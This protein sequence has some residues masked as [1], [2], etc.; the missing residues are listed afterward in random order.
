MGLYNP[1]RPPQQQAW[2]TPTLSPGWSN[3]GGIYS[4][5]AY[6]KDSLGVVHLK[7]ILICSEEDNVQIFVLPMGYRP[8]AVESFNSQYVDDLGV[9][10]LDRIEVSPD[11]QVYS[12]ADQTGQQFSLCGITF[13]AL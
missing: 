2:Q 13:R 9:V 3:Q 7:G 11:G 5:A 1:P 12:R 6:W 8:Q 10:R 4:Q